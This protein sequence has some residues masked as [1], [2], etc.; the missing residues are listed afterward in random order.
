M[1]FTEISGNNCKLE[2]QWLPVMYRARADRLRSRG[3]QAPYVS[4]PV[5]N[6]NR[7]IN[8]SKLFKVSYMRSIGD[9]IA[10]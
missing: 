5:L 3:N 8:L 7:I 2:R 4:L 6:S 10:E 1:A 9:D